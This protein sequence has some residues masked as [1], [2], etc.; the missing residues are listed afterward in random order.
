MSLTPLLDPIVL[1][2]AAT[3]KT[4]PANVI[5]AWHYALNIPFNPRSQNAAHQLENL[6]VGT[7]IPWWSLN[8]SQSELTALN[9]RPQA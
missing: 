9:T 3:H 7:T 1:S 6:G 4:T 5:L 2:I 8:L